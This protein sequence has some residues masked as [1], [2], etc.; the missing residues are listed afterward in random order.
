M[1]DKK[2]P[3]RGCVARSNGIVQRADVV[4]TVVPPPDGNSESPPAEGGDSGREVGV[5]GLEELGVEDCRAGERVE[6]EDWEGVCVCV[7]GC[8]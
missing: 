3:C 4:V 2:F 1:S 5:K 6:E 7:C 8:V